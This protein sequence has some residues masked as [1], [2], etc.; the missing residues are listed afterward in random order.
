VLGATRD[1]FA[2]AS[3][4]IPGTAKKFSAITGFSESVLED[5]LSDRGFD[6]LPMNH[7]AIAEQQRVA[8]I[9]KSLGLIP[10]AINVSDAVRKPQP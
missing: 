6:I 7:D 9:F 4:D 8:D 2:Q 10:V 3:K 5:V 1:I